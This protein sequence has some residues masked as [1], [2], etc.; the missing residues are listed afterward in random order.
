M[1]QSPSRSHFF[2]SGIKG[3]FMVGAQRQP[4]ISGSSPRDWIKSRGLSAFR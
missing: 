3:I 2:A 4:A 1:S